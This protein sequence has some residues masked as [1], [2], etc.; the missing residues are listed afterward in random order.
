HTR[1]AIRLK[2]ICRWSHRIAGV[3]TGTVRYNTRISGVVFL[4]FE[5]NLHQIR[6]DIGNLG[7]D[8]TC[9]PER[10][11]A[12]RF[13]NRESD[14]TWPRKITRD[15]KQNAKHHEQLDADQKHPDAHA[16]LERNE[17]TR[18]WSTCQA[19]ERRS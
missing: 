14:K 4:D 2:T 12:E 10:R 8:S 7:E 3:I 6:T 9:N 1:H 16:R 19:S 17:I 13:T 15:E 11:G 18:V 5:S